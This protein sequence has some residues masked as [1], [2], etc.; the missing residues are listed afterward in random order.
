MVEENDYAK[1]GTT[2]HREEYTKW[3]HFLYSSSTRAEM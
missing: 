2:D 1:V 3:K